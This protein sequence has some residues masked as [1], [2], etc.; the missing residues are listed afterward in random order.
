MW[1]SQHKLRWI[2]ERGEREKK[3]QHRKHTETPIMTSPIST[4]GSW[5]DESNNIKKGQ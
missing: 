5:Q 4:K 3:S 2:V 1:N